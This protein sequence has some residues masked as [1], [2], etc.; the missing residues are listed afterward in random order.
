MSVK[1]KSPPLDEMTPLLAEPVRV[2]SY[3]VRPWTLKRFTR[4]Y[5][6]ARRLVDI[7][8]GQGLTWDNL[9]AFLA[10]KLLDCLPELLPGIPE[11][12]AST[13][14]ISPEEAGDLDLGIATA[15]VLVIFRQNLASLKNFSSLVP[16]KL[17]GAGTLTP[18]P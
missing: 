14:D 9:E 2:G 15:V 3:E 18:S 4:V 12:L 16:G 13:L 8:I 7:L 1:P 5:P 6:A 17:T 10:G 11:L